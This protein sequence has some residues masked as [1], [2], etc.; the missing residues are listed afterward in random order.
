MQP[1]M[2]LLHGEHSV[3]SDRGSNPLRGLRETFQESD[4]LRQPKR[5]IR[6][7]K[8]VCERKW[9]CVICGELV[10]SADLTNAVSATAPCTPRTGRLAAAFK[11]RYTVRIYDFETTQNTLHSDTAKEHVPNVGC[12]QQFCSRCEVIEDCEWECE[13]CGVWSHV[14]WEDPVGDVLTYLCEPRPWSGR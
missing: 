13:C 6:N 1:D 12:M 3:C 8:A 4:L 9:N 5:R 10:V 7:K 2:Q 14:F 11:L